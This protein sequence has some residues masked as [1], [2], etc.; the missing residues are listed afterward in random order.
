MCSCVGPF[1]HIKVPTD[2]HLGALECDR[3]SVVCVPRLA[4]RFLPFR[5][6]VVVI[7][8]RLDW[9][10]KTIRDLTYDVAYKRPVG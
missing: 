5:L 8:V 10:S 1:T 6:R 9:P 7:V 4:K 3:L 2:G